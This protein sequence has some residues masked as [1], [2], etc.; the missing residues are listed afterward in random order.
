M[1][2]RVLAT[3]FVA[4]VVS[5]GGP[6]REQAAESQ[7]LSPKIAAELA[8]SEALADLTR[9]ED[10]SMAR[11]DRLY[12]QQSSHDRGED[13][14]GIELFK[15][16]NKDLNN[17]VCASSDAELGKPLAKASFDLPACPEP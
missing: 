6:R 16:G 3:A 5:C 12:R 17:W 11:P 15:N 1:R 10:L 7:E 9:F 4:L 14:G 2:A 8:D 13:S